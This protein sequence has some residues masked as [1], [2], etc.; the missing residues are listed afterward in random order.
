MCQVITSDNVVADFIRCEEGTRLLAE[1][2]RT[3]SAYLDYIGN[4]QTSQA[5]YD[6][7]DQ[8]KTAH[9]KHLAES[10]GFKSF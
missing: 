2:K 7:Y 8:A 9:Q 5:L 1:V 3:C 4:E 10:Q 6:A